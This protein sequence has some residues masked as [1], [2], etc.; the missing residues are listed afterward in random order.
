VRATELPLRQPAVMRRLSMRGAGAIWA[1]PTATSLCVE[2][3]P[4]AGP[5]SQLEC[6]MLAAMVRVAGGDRGIAQGSRP[7]RASDPA[8]PRR[9]ADLLLISGGVSAGKFD[10]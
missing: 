1:P 8:G 10:L 7:H 2:A 6:A 4:A 3:E 5:D 9:A